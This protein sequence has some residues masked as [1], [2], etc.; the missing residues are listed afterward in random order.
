MLCKFPWGPLALGKP[1]RDSEAW[2]EMGGQDPYLHSDIDPSPPN[3]SGEPSL[4]GTCGLLYP[5]CSPAPSLPEDSPLLSEPI[6]TYCVMQRRQRKEGA[7]C[8]VRLCIEEIY[9]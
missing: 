2:K 5:H 1:S 8:V 4:P 6:W 7:Q 9:Q 3:C